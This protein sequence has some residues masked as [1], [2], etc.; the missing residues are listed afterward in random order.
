MVRKLMRILPMFGLIGLLVAG[1]GPKEEHL[2]WEKMAQYEGADTGPSSDEQ[3]RLSVVAASEQISELKPFVYST[4][5]QEVS[6][7]DFSDYF[8]LAVFQGYHG[9][10]DYSVEVE[11]VKRNRD[12]II[13]YAMFLTPP[14]PAPGEVVG[15]KPM[16]TSPYYVLKVKKTPDLHGEF[17][18]V[19]IADGKEIMRQ[20]QTIP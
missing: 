11:D 3:P 19:L 9:V 20:S 18:F 10:A 8:V 6:Q 7:T 14:T 12:E 13:V 17:I 2:E 16:T 4:V 15:V 5:L 1:C